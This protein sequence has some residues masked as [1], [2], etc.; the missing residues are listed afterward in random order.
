MSPEAPGNLVVLDLRSEQDGF[1]CHV[2]RY[3]PVDPDAG[4]LRVSWNAVSR[5]SGYEPVAGGAA[6]VEVPAGFE[7]REYDAAPDSLRGRLGWIDTVFGDGLMLVVRLP[8]G[9]AIP[10]FRDA[11]PRPVAAKAHDG[12]M[13]LYWLLSE[14]TRVTWRQERVDPGR[15]P[16]LCGTITNDAA[17][18]ERRPMQRPVV[19]SNP[20]A[21]RHY[22]AGVHPDEALVGFHDLCAWIGEKGGDDAQVSFTGILL[23]FLVAVDPV[24]RWFQDYVTRRPI[25]IG[26]MLLSKGFRSIEGLRELAAAHLPPDGPM[27]KKPWTPSAREVLTASG[28]LAQRVGGEGAPI[29]IRHVMGAYCHFH[30]PNHQAQ[31]RRWG[32]DLADWL[33]GYRTCLESLDVTPAE[34]VGWFRLFQELGLLEHDQAVSRTPGASA[35]SQPAGW[36]I[37]IAHAGA[38]KA[39]AEQLCDRLE[40]GGHRVFLDARRLQ[41]GDFWD[42]E[43]PRALATSRLVAVLVSPNYAAAHYLRDEVA[44]AIDRARREGKPRVVPVYLD[45][46]PSRGTSA[47]YG[48]GVIHSIDARAVGGLSAVASQIGALLPAST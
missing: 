43:L 41:P 9:L 42:V 29:G 26:D 5:P 35:G 38:D 21:A 47:P 34:R 3:D 11:E 44:D 13:V 16:A 24:S 27:T 46:L 39:I 14:R 7:Y 19:F 15:V 6:Y 10:G 32:F 31:L 36:D 33:A 18:L 45:G 8:Y 48:L 22:P 28:A 25:T 1:V 17:R 4:F 30:Y 37:F 2:E 20:A 12:R 23:T 40:E